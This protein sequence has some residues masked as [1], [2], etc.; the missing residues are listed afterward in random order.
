MF[1]FLLAVAA[2]LALLP[3][4]AFA[5]G[6]GQ[7]QVCGASGCS[8][9]S[10]QTDGGAF[11][12]GTPGAQPPALSDYYR[13]TFTIEAGPGAT[14][15]NGRKTAT[16]SIYYVPSAGVTRQTADYG[17]GEWL[18]L[19]PQSRQTLDRLAA[20]LKPFPKPTLTGA[21]VGSRRVRNP[22]SYEQLYS[23]ES[24]GLA[25]PGKSDWL[26]ITLRSKRPSPWTDGFAV[27]QYSPSA[28]VLQRDGEF[29]RLPDALGPKLAAGHSLAPRRN[30][31]PWFVLIAAGLGIGALAVVV[32]IAAWRVRF[33]LLAGRP[34]TA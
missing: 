2:A 12:G 1:R 3:A 6:V 32:I 8:E 7:V 27:L 28:K 23:I 14:F 31:F 33:R 13:L 22:G 11:F 29:V 21:L 9:P 10:G 18:A 30:G 20:G 4:S 19:S 24:A 34:E 25:V 15:V 5:K 17:I 26:T 16:H